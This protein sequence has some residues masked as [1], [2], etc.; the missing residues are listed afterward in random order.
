MPEVT[1]VVWG[2]QGNQ[3]QQKAHAYS[4]ESGEGINALSKTW[5]GLPGMRGLG[6]GVKSFLWIKYNTLGE[7]AGAIL[8][9]KQMGE[10][11][12]AREEG[13]REENQRKSRAGDEKDCCGE[14]RRWKLEDG[15]AEVQ[16]C[17]GTVGSMGGTG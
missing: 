7:L 4:A 12:R 9:S 15:G 5:D 2:C 8:L 14:I 6:K 17:G 3:Q 10:G 1:G 13:E 16:L 11:K